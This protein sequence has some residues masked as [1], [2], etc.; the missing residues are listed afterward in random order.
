[1]KNE[2]IIFVGPMFGGKNEISL[3]SSHELTK[4]MQRKR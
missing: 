4:G 3:H 1:M 2:F